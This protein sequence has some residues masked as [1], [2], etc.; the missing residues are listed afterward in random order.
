MSPQYI[1]L[2]NDVM[3]ITKGGNSTKVSL[4]CSYHQG[5]VAVLGPVATGR[6][7]GCMYNGPGL[8][9]Q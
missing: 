1:N 5:N 7:H 4:T 6:K 9:H 8:G 2:N 3:I